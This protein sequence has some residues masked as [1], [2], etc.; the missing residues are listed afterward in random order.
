MSFNNIAGT[1]EIEINSENE[2]SGV[3]FLQQESD[4]S[5]EGSNVKANLAM[6]EKMR[7]DGVKKLVEDLRKELPN[8]NYKCKSAN[9]VITNSIDYLTK[10]MAERNNVIQEYENKVKLFAELQN[11]RNQQL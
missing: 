10:M 9:E 8:D 6:K 1:I 11:I 2:V 5:T 7:R 3:K 4:A